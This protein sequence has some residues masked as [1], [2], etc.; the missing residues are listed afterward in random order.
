MVRYILD[1]YKGI[2]ETIRMNNKLEDFMVT[3]CERLF[4]FCVKYKRKTEFKKICYD[5]NLFI[6]KIVNINYNLHPKTSFTIDIQ[7]KESNDRYF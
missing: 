1:A 7:I 3:I 2:I 6:S 4:D 5:F